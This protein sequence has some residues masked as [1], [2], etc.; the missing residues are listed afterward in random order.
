MRYSTAL[1]VKWV[2][3]RR[4][5]AYRFGIGVGVGGLLLLTA[6]NSSARAL[7]NWAFGTLL[8]AT[9]MLLFGI[10]VMV[11]PIV[12]KANR[13][14]R[15]T[16]PQYAG[17]RRNR[18]GY[19][20]DKLTCWVVK[21]AIGTAFFIAGI[22]FVALLSNGLLVG[23]RLIVAAMWFFSLGKFLASRVLPAHMVGRHAPG[24]ALGYIVGVT[25]SPQLTHVV[26]AAFG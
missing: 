9:G 4:G 14:N 6:S 25:F 24:I 5:N 12:T 10:L 21:R 15:S 2:S 16:S 3:D 17:L 20:V 26:T 11:A 23:S 22:A 19:T 18:L 13:R 1:I 7:V 8:G